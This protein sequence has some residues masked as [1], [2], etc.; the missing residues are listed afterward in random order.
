MFVT[1]LGDDVGI[2]RLTLLLVWSRLSL[3]KVCKQSSCKNACMG[4]YDLYT[5]L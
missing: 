1:V 4:D 5:T 2:Y 3:M